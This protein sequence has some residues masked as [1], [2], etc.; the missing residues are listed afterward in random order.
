MPIIF[1]VISLLIAGCSKTTS[2]EQAVVTGQEIGAK[3]AM[4]VLDKGGT[5]S[6]A[7]AAALLTESNT[8]PY[9]S[10]LGGGFFA[11]YYDAATKKVYSIDAREE[12]PRNINPRIF[13]EPNSEK[14]IRF[15]PDRQSSAA[16]VGVP[17]VADGLALM[18]KNFGKLS[19]A[20][21]LDPA[22]KIAEKGFEVSEYFATRLLEKSQESCEAVGVPRLAMFPATRKIFFKPLSQVKK[23]TL[24]CKSDDFYQWQPVQAGELIT[25]TDYART[26]KLLAKDGYRAFY[27]GAIAEA[28]VKMLNNANPGYVD[29]PN[30]PFSLKK[31]SM[32]LK[33]LE[34]YRAVFR[35]TI[36][37]AYVDKKGNAFEVVGMGP[38]SSGG[39]A[40][41]QALNILDNPN[42]TEREFNMSRLGT[43]RANKRKAHRNAFLQSEVTKL[44]FADRNKYLG[45]ED[46]VTDLKEIKE[47][48]ISPDYADAL[49]KSFMGMFEQEDLE[50][51]SFTPISQEKFRF[52]STSKQQKDLPPSVFDFVS[53]KNFRATNTCIKSIYNREHGTSHIAIKDKFGN[54]LSAT[55]TIEWYFGNGM[56]VPNF[57]FLLNNQ[58]TD[59]DP[60]LGHC[61]SIESGLRQRVSA[62]GQTSDGKEANQ[63]WGAKRPRS[64]MSPTM[65]LQDGKPILALGASGGS[66][67]IGS[68]FQVFLNV[69]EHGLGIEEAIKLP[70]IYNR[71]TDNIYMEEELH[72]DKKL[73]DFLAWSSTYS[74]SQ[75]SA[76]LADP[77]PKYF[78]LLKSHMTSAQGISIDPESGKAKA[79]ADPRREGKALHK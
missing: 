69:F 11:L 78:K 10:G 71:N 7:F 54:V 51:L 18:Q 74:P 42:T 4:E 13:L 25:N 5:A 40:I 73:Y 66:T 50:D 8:K 3:A 32:D 65:V 12:A 45:D 56:V 62:L 39:I 47:A 1:L 61:N 26:L 77:D 24:K 43:L 59:F 41:A 23:P 28:M 64:S 20:E 37:S 70:R 30:L 53:N 48:L 15:F 55:A 35:E 2:G 27:T 52:M 57:G 6:D 75:F 9:S 36:N 68:V 31:S 58:L 38:P 46:F 29:L 17:G 14:P 79:A 34:N 21:V 49:R 44:A 19:T 76:A 67:I 16:A 72:K 63:T 60:T 22:I 33:D